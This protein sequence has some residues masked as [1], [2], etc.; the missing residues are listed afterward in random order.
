MPEEMGKFEFLLGDCSLD[1]HVPES[2]FSQ[3][4]TGSGS[5]TFQRIFNDKYVTFDY[6]CRLTD[7]NGRAKSIFAWDTKDHVYRCWWFEDSGN[8]NS[9]VCNFISD[10]VLYFHW[11]DGLLSQTFTK[12]DANMIILKMDQPIFG[13]RKELV[14]EVVLTRKP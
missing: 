14:L 1:Y 8:F 13:D 10:D 7:G 2:S 9:A 4:D 11:N 6:E 12:K 3:A 5:G